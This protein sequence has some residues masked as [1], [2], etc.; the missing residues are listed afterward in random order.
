MFKSWMFFKVELIGPTSRLDEESK[1][2]KR[3][4]GESSICSIQLKLKWGRIGRGT[5]L[6]REVPELIC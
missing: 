1:K 6:R 5:C 4:K 3:V 2:R